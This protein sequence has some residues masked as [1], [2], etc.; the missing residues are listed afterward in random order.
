M[1]PEFSTAR[2]ITITAAITM[3]TGLEK[4]SNIA[5]GGTTPDRAATDSASNATMSYRIRSDANNT[6]IA[7]TMANAIPCCSVIAGKRSCLRQVPR[8]QHRRHHSPSCGPAFAR[9]LPFRECS[10]MP[11]SA[12]MDMTN[13]SEPT[14][15]LDVLGS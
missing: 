13:A 9:V 4:P 15:A 5:R 7:P 3:T 10:I 2:P 11:E 6:S 1:I 12:C 14:A 8:R